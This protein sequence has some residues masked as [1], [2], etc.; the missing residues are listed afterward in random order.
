MVNYFKHSHLRIYDFIRNPFSVARGKGLVFKGSKKELEQ[1]EAMPFEEA[2]SSLLEYE[3]VFDND[4]DR[5]AYDKEFGGP[6]FFLSII[7]HGQVVTAEGHI[8]RIRM[9]PSK[10][11][12]HV[13][14]IYLG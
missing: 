1:H 7:Y 6:S 11:K 3:N 2:K 5:E 9:Y 10:C 4:T 14:A 8:H 12:K 13:D